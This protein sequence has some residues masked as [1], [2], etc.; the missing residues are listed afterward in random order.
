[1]ASIGLQITI[2]DPHMD[3]L[4]PHLDNL[5]PYLTSINIHMATLG[6]YPMIVLCRILKPFT[7]TQTG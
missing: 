1:M 5:D 4:D 7:T 6:S 3:T 2:L